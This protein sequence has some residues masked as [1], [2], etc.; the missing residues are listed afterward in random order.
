VH[1][2]QGS[3]SDG[4]SADDFTDGLDGR[5]WLDA[6]CASHMRI[7]G[8]MTFG[9]QAE[10][11]ND[12]QSR[13]AWRVLDAHPDAETTRIEFRAQALL[14]ALDLLC[15]RGEIGGGSAL[16]KDFRGAGLGSP[17][18]RKWRSENE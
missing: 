7:H 12:F 14:D 8:Q 5:A 11:V 2:M 10:H 17:R 9:S 13:S 18:R 15:C 4:G 6:A 1:D 3:A 16:R